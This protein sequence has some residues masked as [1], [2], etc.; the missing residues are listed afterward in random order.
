MAVT[1]AKVWVWKWQ[2]E[3]SKKYVIKNN[4]VAPLVGASSLVLQD[5]RF[6]SHSRELWSRWDRS[7]G[8][9]DLICVD[10]RHV[11]GG[12][13]LL[14][15]P[16]LSKNEALRVRVTCPRSHSDWEGWH[17]GDSDWGHLTYWPG[18][19]FCAGSALYLSWPHTW[20]VYSS[21][22]DMVESGIG[23]KFRVGQ[24]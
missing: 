20:S 9:R 12:R 19:L 4:S 10:Q 15:P 3:V 6:T 13:P 1:W 8:S 14:W 16:H 18:I 7:L 23:L 5:F 21:I 24:K 11:K 17:V 22:L 2:P